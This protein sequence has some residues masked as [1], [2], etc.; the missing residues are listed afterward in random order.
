MLIAKE[1]RLSEVFLA[2]IP[3]AVTLGGAHCPMGQGCC[4][5]ML[6]SGVQP[7]PQSL[8]RVALPCCKAAPSF[9]PKP[10]RQEVLT[11]ARCHTR[12]AKYPESQAATWACYKTMQ[13]CSQVRRLCT[14]GTDS[15]LCFQWEAA[16]GMQKHG[17]G[18][19]SLILLKAAPR[20]I[21]GWLGAP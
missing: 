14:G 17:E 7:L 6:L 3:L 9:N 12:V 19:T 13:A 8:G 5:E 15:A 10:R 4:R 1:L 20:L 16:R 2:C 21:L 11:C 18:V